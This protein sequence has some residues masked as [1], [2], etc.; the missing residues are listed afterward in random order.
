MQPAVMPKPKTDPALIPEYS[1]ELADSN[2][3]AK[4]WLLLDIDATGKVT[5]LKFLRRPG[6]K[7]DGIA[8]KTAFKLQFEPAL[9]HANHP[10][11]SL[12]VWSF[13]W[14]SWFWLQR[15]HHDMSKPMPA[16]VSEVPCQR[17]TTHHAEYRE[18]AGPDFAHG[19][20]E[21][22]IRPRR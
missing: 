21:S 7:L 8:M 20:V 11:R 13:E 22:W 16:Y 9:D 3:W 18:C 2:Q 12:L 4:A 17:G 19:L 6:Y 15:E 14:P 10:I 1:D 5:Q